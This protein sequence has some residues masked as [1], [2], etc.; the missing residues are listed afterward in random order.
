M[1]LPASASRPPS[2][3]PARPGLQR[4]TPDR[5]TF[6]AVRAR[7]FAPLVLI[8]PFACTRTNP[9][10]FQA[11]TPPEEC[12]TLNAP[13]DYVTASKTCAAYKSCV[14]SATCTCTEPETPYVCPSLRPWAAMKHADACGSFDGTFPAPVAG[15]CVATDPSAQAKE[16]GGKDSTVPGRWHLGDGH[17]VQ[18]AGHEQILHGAGVVSA[19]LSDVMLIPGTRFAVAIDG[20]VR[21]NA[22]YS[23]DLD[24]LALDKPALL[25]TV[26]FA[27]PAQ[28]DYGL[29]FVAPNHVY[30]SGAANGAVFAFL[31]NLTTGVLTRDSGSDLPMGKATFPNASQTEWYVGGL[32]ATPDGKKLVVAPSVGETAVRVVDLATKK[33]TSIDVGTSKERFGVFADPNDATGNTLWVTSYDPR[34]AVRIDLATNT[35]T[36]TVPTGKNPEGIAFLDATTMV[37]ADSD[38]DTLRVIDTT[39][40]TTKQ[41]LALRNDG[42]TGAQP[43][44]LAYDATRKRLY[45]ALSGINAIG[46]YDVDTASATVLSPR[47]QIPTGWFPTGLRLRADGSLVVVNAKGRGIGPVAGSTDTPDAT[48]GSIQ[49]IPAPQDADYAA[50]SAIV[51]S[52][53]SKTATEGFPTVTCNGA[54][55]DFPVPLDEKSGPSTKIQHVVY[56]VRENKTFDA[57]FGDLPKVNGSPAAVMSPGRMDEF[58]NNARRIAQAF[59]N[60]D[61]YYI[62]A[63]QSLQGHVWTS[64]GRSTDYIERTWSSSWGRGVRSPKAG[65]DRVFGSPGEGSLF[66]WAERNGIRYDDMGEIVGGGDQGFDTNYPG[67]V[68]SNSTPDTEKA[69]YIAARARAVCDLKPLTYVVLPNDHTYGDEPG[70]PTPEL[71][72]AVNDV[73]TGMILDALSHSPI[74]ASTLLIVTEDDPQE[75]DDHVSGHRTPLF[76]ASPWIKRGYVSKTNV[77]TASI[78]KLIANILGKPYQSESVASAAIPYD[79]FTSTPDYTSYSYQPLQTKV[80]CNPAKG[81]SSGPSG[82]DFSRPDNQPGLD[83]TVE[84]RMRAIAKP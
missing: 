78:H 57:I 40:G 22:V 33:Y 51:T 76:M 82:W 5:D 8:L 30:V 23:V 59:T 72:I 29:A 25:T 65:I 1:T 81:W 47:G 60:F 64:Y 73:A 10:D 20:G 79:A 21:D 44:V 15:K 71:M 66:V 12:A 32:A 80:S 77:S 52:S 6:P 43:S 28:V 49:L 9:D 63:E 14:Y 67:L 24:E 69:C 36:S 42:L 62:A 41:T 74:W 17:F 84:R 68:Y 48:E 34:V 83:D 18:P 37:V 35:A 54:P 4:A 56:V 2:T 31:I 70:K 55:Y 46:A 58:W 16:Y 75:G 3:S 61:N 7:H 11:P 26:E 45:A 19:F 39:T 13:E 50:L 53:R 27:R 38:D